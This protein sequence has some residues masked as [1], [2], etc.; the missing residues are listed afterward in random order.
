MRKLYIM[1]VSQIKKS[2]KLEL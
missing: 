1:S 2:S